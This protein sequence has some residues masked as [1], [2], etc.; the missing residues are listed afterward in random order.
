VFLQKSIQQNLGNPEVSFPKVFDSLPEVRQSALR[1]Q[2]EN[3][4]RARH[5]M[6]DSPAG[7]TIACRPG[8]APIKTCAHAEAKFPAQCIAP[9]RSRK[10]KTGRILWRL[11]PPE[12]ARVQRRLKA[13]WAL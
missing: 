13:W 2:I 12:G 8:S 3:A 5:E 10:L 1:R 6:T 9:Q 11:K 7:S 4:Q